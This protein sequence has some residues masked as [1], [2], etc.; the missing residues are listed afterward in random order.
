MDSEK[1]LIN[2]ELLIWCSV[3]VVELFILAWL[4]QSAFMLILGLVL[5]SP[6]LAAFNWPVPTKAIAENTDNTA[7]E[8]K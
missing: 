7:A 4:V 2:T 3:V 6:I 8:A 5:I 1:T